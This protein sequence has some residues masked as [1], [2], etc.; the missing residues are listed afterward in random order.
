MGAPKKAVTD[1]RKHYC[2][3]CPTNIESGDLTPARAVMHM[4][5]KRME[6]HCGNG[7]RVPR[8]ETILR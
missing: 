4:P 2:P 3:L 7:H 8:R 1:I 5:G 6:Y